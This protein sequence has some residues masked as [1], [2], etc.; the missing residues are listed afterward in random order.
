MLRRECS[1]AF[2]PVLEPY[3]LASRGQYTSVTGLLRRTHSFNRSLWIHIV[4][5]RSN[6]NIFFL[7]SHHFVGAKQYP[8]ALKLAQGREILVSYEKTGSDAGLPSGAVS[9]W[10]DCTVLLVCA[11]QP[12]G[13]DGGERLIIPSFSLQETRLHLCVH[14]RRCVTSTGTCIHVSSCWR[15]L[16]N[17][18]CQLGFCFSSSGGVFLCTG[19]H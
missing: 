9:S 5:S 1:S 18:S 3:S 17:L 12:E 16:Y 11:A 15:Q 10:L 8:V 4:S 19:L 14:C 13:T 2:L 6:I 7:C